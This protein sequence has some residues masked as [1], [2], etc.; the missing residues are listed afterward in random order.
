MNGNNL[1]VNNHDLGF[2]FQLLALAHGEKN[3]VPYYFQIVGF[4]TLSIHT[5]LLQMY[6]VLIKKM[7]RSVHQSFHVLYIHFF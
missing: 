4:L 2:N 5:C 7:N 3:R 1:I 6:A